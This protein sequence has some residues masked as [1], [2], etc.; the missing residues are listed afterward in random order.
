MMRQVKGQFGWT[1]AQDANGNWYAFW[2]SGAFWGEPGMEKPNFFQHWDTYKEL[3]EY[4][5]QPGHWNLDEGI[6]YW[7]DF[8]VYGKTHKLGWEQWQFKY[9]LPA[10]YE[11]AVTFFVL[12]DECW[13]PIPNHFGVCLGQE[14]PHCELPLKETS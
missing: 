10:D 8:W 4:T 9:D 5:D 14:N 12:K 6:W 3:Y 7:G 2:K 11:K 1:W 13:G